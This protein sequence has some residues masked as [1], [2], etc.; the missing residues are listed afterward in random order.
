MI[1]ANAFAARNTI[2]ITRSTI[3]PDLGHS[4]TAVN[5]MYSVRGQQLYESGGT[6]AGPLLVVTCG[7]RR[8]QLLRLYLPRL[9]STVATSLRHLRRC[10]FSE[11]A[12][13]GGRH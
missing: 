6:A 13:H 7:A 9:S 11:G 10:G 3:P 12:R 8:R 5:F 4:S 1:V 2:S